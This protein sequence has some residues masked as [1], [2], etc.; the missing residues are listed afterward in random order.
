MIN[1]KNF[2]DNHNDLWDGT[3]NNVTAHISVSNPMYAST[4]G[5]LVARY[6]ITLL[7][8]QKGNPILFK[9][10]TFI[11]EDQIQSEVNTLKDIVFVAFRNQVEPSVTNNL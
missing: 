6:K 11:V 9:E 4:L 1:Y 5:E 8:F 10:R 2:P 3:T 7:A